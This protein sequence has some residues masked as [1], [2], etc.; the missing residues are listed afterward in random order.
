MSIELA[1]IFLFSLLLVLLAFGVP[2]A[3]A[4]G[5]SAVII[6]MTLWGVPG[7][8]IIL[9]SA[10]NNMKTIILAAVPLFIFMGAILQY[11]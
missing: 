2:V 5:G 8:T 11:S 9:Q 3:F 1:T 7:F 10:L 6:C 4:L